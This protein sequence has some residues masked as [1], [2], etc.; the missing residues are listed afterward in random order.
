LAKSADRAFGVGWSL[1]PRLFGQKPSLHRTGNPIRQIPAFGKANSPCGGETAAGIYV[2]VWA[3]RMTFAVE[4]VATRHGNAFV[5]G[6][7]AVMT[8]SSRWNLHLEAGQHRTNCAKP[9]PLAA[10][11]EIVQWRAD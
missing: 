8:S 5:V 10:F 7:D 3:E 11:A 9:A 6:R 4:S 1:L 2:A